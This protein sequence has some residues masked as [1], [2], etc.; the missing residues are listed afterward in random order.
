[1]WMLS[2]RAPCFKTIIISILQ[3]Q[4]CYFSIYESGWES[5]NAVLLDIL[6][7]F[8]SFNFVAAAC[9]FF[10]IHL[11][12]FIYSTVD[13]RTFFCI[14]SHFAVERAICISLQFIQD[15]LKDW[16][17]FT[18]HSLTQFNCI[19]VFDFIYYLCHL[20]AIRTIKQS[21][22]R[23]KSWA[24]KRK[25]KR[26]RACECRNYV[27]NLPRCFPF[28]HTW[29]RD[30]FEVHTMGFWISNEFSVHTW[31]PW[32]KTYDNTAKRHTFRIYKRVLWISKMHIFQ[33]RIFN[34]HHYFISTFSCF[35]ISLSLSVRLARCQL[36]L[37]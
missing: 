35:S 34:S 28:W 20:C 30:K 2:S 19:L 21:R 27:T 13:G 14:L 16:S 4:N 36:L 15:E 17:L 22:C 3:W 26:R 31:M 24:Q 37:F 33:L 12:K 9:L 23:T 8:F 1:M 10:L 32:Q 18:T 29:K 6:R 5:F 25:T 7:L 11:C